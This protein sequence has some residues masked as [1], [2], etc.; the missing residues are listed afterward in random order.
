MSRIEC[1]VEYREDHGEP[2]EKGMIDYCYDCDYITLKIENRLF[3]ARHYRDTPDEVSILSIRGAED[4]EF[5]AY[6]RA[7]METDPPGDSSFVFVQNG[8]SGIQDHI[9]Y[10]SQLF[11]EAVNYLVS[12]FQA[13]RI[14]LLD[15]SNPLG[16]SD[17][18]LA[19]IQNKLNPEA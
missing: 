10:E 6:F 4:G 1:H 16:Y 8:I 7:R 19:R 2:D 12:N 14:K 9:P 13:K 18:D 5:S 3:Q 17:V 11:H 15:S